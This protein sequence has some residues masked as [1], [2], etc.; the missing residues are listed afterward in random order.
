ML[1]FFGALLG[2][3]ASGCTS[4]AAAVIV[5]NCFGEQSGTPMGITMAGTGICG[6]LQGFF[7][8]SLLA[9]LGWRVVYAIL[10]VC[11]EAALL[12]AAF[13]I[14]EQR[15]VT[16]HADTKQKGMN[17]HGTSVKWTTGLVLFMA[18]IFVFSLHGSF[19][20]HMQAHFTEQGIPETITGIFMSIFNVFVISFKVSQG[21]LFD[22]FGATMT[23]AAAFSVFAVGL[24][25]ATSQ[26]PMILF[27]S[28]ICLAFGMSAET[29]LTPLLTR[30]I[31]GIR[32]YA[33][34]YARISMAYNCGTAF[35]SPLWGTIYDVTKS[36]KVGL[37]CTP[38]IIM[39]D[40][41]LIVVMIRKKRNVYDT[42]L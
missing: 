19:L 33:I 36:Y 29:V 2:V 17:E 12:G 8:P 20:H 9:N 41:L 21:Y 35:G 39:A 4:L 26:E 13:L 37:L 1:Y 5:N 14:G 3:V 18:C 30:E 16:T 28:M 22:R 34:I 31:W 27:I 25:L 6:I 40:L 11:W 32:E 15:V 23:T 24:L 10:G 38:W 7:I 42:T